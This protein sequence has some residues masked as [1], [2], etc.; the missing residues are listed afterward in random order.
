MSEY[1]VP[2]NVLPTAGPSLILKTFALE[3]VKTLAYGAGVAGAIARSKFQKNTNPYNQM[4]EVDADKPL[5]LSELGTPVFCNLEIQAGTWT[6]DNGVKHDWPFTV[7]DTVL[8]TVDQT[9]EIIK[10]KI[11]GRKGGTVKEYISDGDFSIN[12]KTLIIGPRKKMPLQEVADFMK[13]LLAPM[14]LSVNSRYLQNLGID[15]FV[16]DR[17]SLPQAEGAYHY[18]M[19]ELFC[20]SDQ[21]VELKIK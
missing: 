17:Y 11:Q 6:D 8:I 20:S 9:K 19:V 14:S 16:I 3:S 13:V 1:I 10:T 5:Y 2:K 7:M 21:P 12:I 4:A 15:N 18:Q